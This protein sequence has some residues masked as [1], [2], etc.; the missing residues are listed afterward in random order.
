MDANDTSKYRKRKR[1]SRDN[2]VEEKRTQRKEWK[3]RKQQAKRVKSTPSINGRN[4]GSEEQKAVI[5]HQK[6]T[7]VDI[8]RITSSSQNSLNVHA[9]TTIKSKSLAEKIKPKTQMAAA[10]SRSA[11]MLRLAVTKAAEGKP[12]KKVQTSAEVKFRTEH[13]NRTN[14]NARSSKLQQLMPAPPERNLRAVK[15]QIVVKEKSLLKEL[16]PG[17]IDYL[18][19]DAVGSGSYG[20]CYRARYRGINVVVKKMIHRDTERD[21]LRAK[22]E[23][24][25]EA[26]VLTALGDHEGLP[27]LIGITTA[28]EPFCLVT[29][30]H[31]IIEQSVTLHQAANNKIITPAECIHLFVKICSALEHVHSK[32]FLHNDIK[33]NNVVLDQ[34]GPGQYNPVLI[35]FGKSTRPSAATTVTVNE[36]SVHGKSYLAPEVLKY[37]SYSPASDIYSMGRMLKAISTIMGFYDKVRAVT[38]TATELKPSHRANIK[39]LARKISLVHF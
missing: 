35:D 30:F 4:D 7:V 25:H 11:L 2:T 24:V 3:K 34:T 32:G 17:H 39:Q 21:K 26:E 10:N 23:V 37:R 12:S 9:P 29:Q 15:K 33:S 1:K 38:K 22:R 18:P 16:E 5:E 14:N 28:N 36:K 8:T 19:L 20:L 27:M 31:G 13:S 6:R